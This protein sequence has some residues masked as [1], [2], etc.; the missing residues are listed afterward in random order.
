M[1][2]GQQVSQRID[3]VPL[4]GALQMP[5]TVTLVGALPQKEVAAGLGHAEEKLPLGGVQHTLLHLTQFDIEHFLKLLA[6]QRV[7]YHNLVEAVHEFRRELPPRRFHR[8][9]FYLLIQ[10]ADG[11][12]GRLGETHATLHELDNLTA[13]QVGG[14]EDHG[15]REIHLTVIAQGQSRLV[16]NPKQ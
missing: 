3:D 15:L 7:E 1:I 13:T 2:S 11:F 14:Q 9:T 10:A 6:L 5:G 8:R 16:Q 12:V 4:Y